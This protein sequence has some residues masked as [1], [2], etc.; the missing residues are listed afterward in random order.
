MYCW[1]SFGGLSTAHMLFIT[2]L[3]EFMTVGLSLGFIL[4]SNIFNIHRSVVQ[5]V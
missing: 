2:V 4:V 5:H 1:F 3:S